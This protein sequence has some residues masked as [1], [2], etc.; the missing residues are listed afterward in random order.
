M[1]INIGGRGEQAGGLSIRGTTGWCAC[2]GSF[3]R[4]GCAVSA[5][6]LARKLTGRKTIPL[7]ILSRVLVGMGAQEVR[8]YATQRLAACQRA[9]LAFGVHILGRSL[10]FCLDHQVYSFSS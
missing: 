6:S 2:G 10:A 8:R 3:Y 7:G 1:S 5:G 9:P 4:T